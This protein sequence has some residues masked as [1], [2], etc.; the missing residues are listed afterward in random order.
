MSKAVP[1]VQM[2]PV[3]PAFA[4]PID[5]PFSWLRGMAATI[6]ERM[7]ARGAVVLHGLPL[8]GPASLAEARDALAIERHTLTEAFNG[9]RDFGHGIVSP[10]SW[11][12]DRP[13]CPFQEGAFSADYPSVV[14][15]ACVSPPEG[16][17]Q[18]HLSDVR[19]IAEQLPVHLADRVRA[20][21]WML[22][23]VFHVGFGISW[24]EAFS[25]PDRAALDR[26]LQAARIEAE[27]MPNGT[28][29][30]MRHRPGVVVHPATGKECWFNQIAFLN[31][32]SLDPAER[33]VM[34]RSFGRYLPMNTFFGDG[35][36]LSDEDLTA[37]Q[38]AYD[39]VKIGV[40]WRSGDLLVTDNISMAQGRSAYQ[41]SPEFLVSLGGEWH[42]IPGPKPETQKA[43]TSY[44]E[45][46]A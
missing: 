43:S 4:A 31:A 6:R 44:P 30:T 38:D 36:P 34:A 42:S 1:T 19:R 11:P 41:G 8:T 37:I 24:Q 39:T 46:E 5:H 9:R 27:W 20:D 25:A 35:S 15:T 18:A 45:S 13:I 40:Q 7:L 22:S 26:V 21:G 12:L 17:G 32:G 10:I 33:A 16:D 3:L 2:E 14:L 28:L 23:R 29:H